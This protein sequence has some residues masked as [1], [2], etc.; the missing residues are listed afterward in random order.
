MKHTRLALALM[1]VAL[2]P[3]GA[4]AQS[5]SIRFENTSTDSGPVQVPVLDGTPM[6][7]D[8]DNNLVASCELEP[9]T[10]VCKGM[11]TGPSA[12]APTLTLG[13]SP[14]TIE[15]GQSSRLTWTTGNAPQVC[16]PSASP[17]LSAWTGTTSDVKLKSVN[18]SFQDVTFTSP[19]T[20]SLSLRCWNEGGASPLRTASVTVEESEN[21][22]PSDGCTI[23]PNL[24]DPWYTPS[25]YTERVVS[26]PDAFNDTPFFTP[27]TYM[28][29]IGSFVI[30]NASVATNYISIPFVPQADTSYKISWWEAQAIPVVGYNAGRPAR[31]AYLT[32]SKCK[33]DFRKEDNQSADTSLKRGCRRASQTGSIGFSSKISTSTTSTCAV[34]PGEQYYLNVLFADPNE[35]LPSVSCVSGERCEINTVPSFN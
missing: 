16:V 5:T 6:A 18:G 26:W 4:V 33:G 11:N 32:V 1:A 17:A 19:G 29:P 9:D 35:A 10:T 31:T 13:A 8:E 15:E 3:L 24:A 34:T 2:V 27:T 12:A 21:P 23:D 28:N 22:P 25:G 7:F 30:S 14:A 20:Y